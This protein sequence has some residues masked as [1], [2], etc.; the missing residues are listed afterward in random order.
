MPGHAR[1]AVLAMRARH[2]RLRA[3]GDVEGAERYLLTIPDDASVYESVQLWRDNV[4]CIALPSVDR[5]ID[6]VVA[7]VAALYR[8]AG[9]PLRDDP[10]GRRRGAAGAWLGSPRCRA[11]M[12]ERG[13]T[14]VGQLQ[15]DFV[16]RCRAILARH[17]LAFAGWEETALE[18]R[19]RHRRGLREGT[20]AVEGAAAAPRLRRSTP[21]TT[22]GARARKTCAYRLANAGYD[23]GAGECRQP[24]LRPRVCQGSA[25]AGLLLGRLRRDPPRL[26]L[27]PAGHDRQRA[28]TDPMGQSAAARTAGRDG[29]PDAGRAAPHRRPAGAAVG[30]KRPH[31]R[32]HR[33]PGRA[34]PAGAGRAGLGAGSRLVRDRR[35]R[36]RAHAHRRRLERIRQPPRPARAG[37]PGPRAAGLRLPVAAAGRRAPA[38]RSTRTSPCRAWRCITLWTAASPT[39][40]PALHG[41]GGG[42]GRAAV[43]KV[44]TFDTRG[45]KSRIVTTGL[46]G[47]IR[48]PPEADPPKALSQCAIRWPG[49]PRLYLAQGLPF[50]AVAL[51]AGLM[52]KSMGVPNE[53][54]ARWTG[55]LGWPG[56][57]RRCGALSWNWPRARSAVV[58]CRSS[59]A[60]RSAALALALQLPAWFALAIALLA[61]VSLASSTHDI[62]ADGLYIASLSS[63]S[64]PP[65]PAGR[66][67]SSTAPSSCR[68]AG[69]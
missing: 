26:R 21:G 50:Y 31:A 54:I 58:C 38:G 4:I 29:A 55:V 68:W 13:W 14:H 35:C 6:T 60:S 12:R 24:V 66:A 10:H 41:T 52:F 57:S 5:F 61:V 25:G 53:Q 44:A 8:E 69:S 23:G 28:A 45:R 51:V 9:V 46:P 63:A 15:A 27:L 56:C 11:L 59:A 37:A 40:Q 17:G 20:L 1:A 3:Q 42:S 7:D 49:C 36:P 30:R 19:R 48:G 65:T 62:A 2:D 18:I 67:P 64:R 22:P 33:I 34:A 47:S 32:P 39:R 16:D 43:F